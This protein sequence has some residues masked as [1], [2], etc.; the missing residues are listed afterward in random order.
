MESTLS[1]E[2]LWIESQRDGEILLIKQCSSGKT[3]PRENDGIR[4][5]LYSALSLEFCIIYDF[6]YYAVEHATKALTSRVTMC[7]S[8]VDDPDNSLHSMPA[9]QFL[10]GTIGN[11]KL[12]TLRPPHRSMR[13]AVPAEAL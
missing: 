3:R 12:V 10:G 5:S 2:L 9:H 8:Q 11:N 4:F 1:F 13:I 6:E 7:H